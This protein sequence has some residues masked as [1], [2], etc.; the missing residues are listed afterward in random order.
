MQALEGSGQ[1]KSLSECGGTDS[2]QEMQPGKIDR[3]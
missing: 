3:A 2:V 1:P